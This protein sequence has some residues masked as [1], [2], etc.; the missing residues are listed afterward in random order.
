MDF[1]TVTERLWRGPQPDYGEL[2]KLQEQGLTAVVNL[3]DES[4]ESKS[5]CQRL[6]LGYHFFPIVDWTTPNPRQVE[7]FLELFERYPE[8]RYLVHCWGGVGRTG[9]FVCCYRISMGLMNARDAID[10]SDEETPHLQ[11]NAIQRQFVMGWR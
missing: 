6:G 5:L 11:M 8:E 7:S 4:E 10:L 3:R 9:V 2:I 1:L